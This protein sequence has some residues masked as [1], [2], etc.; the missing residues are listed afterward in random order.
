MVV[1]VIE[2]ALSSREF[3]CST[4]TR[5][6][7]LNFLWRTAPTPSPITSMLASAGMN[8]A[9]PPKSPTTSQTL[10]A[11]AATRTQDTTGSPIGLLI[12]VSGL[13]VSIL[14]I[15]FMSFSNTFMGIALWGES[16]EVDFFQVVAALAQQRRGFQRIA[17][18]H[19]LHTSQGVLVGNHRDIADVLLEAVQVEAEHAKQRVLAVD[20][21]E[22]GLPVRNA[23]PLELAAGLAKRIDVTAPAQG[24]GVMQIENRACRL[25]TAAVKAD[26]AGPGGDRHQGEGHGKIRDLSQLHRTLEHQ[27]QTVLVRLAD[28]GDAVEGDVP[29]AVDVDPRTLFASLL[30]DAFGDPFGQVVAVLDVDRRRLRG[31]LFQD[32]ASVVHGA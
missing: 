15:A 24:L 19:A 29:R 3:S 18:A 9:K 12:S 31:R 23:D 25:V 4:T 21:V 7:S 27:H 20:P 28:A 1:Q 8:R 17:F 2:N 16:D 11:W 13:R 22:L 30:Q 10:L 32:A 6:P 14:L 26:E 5:P